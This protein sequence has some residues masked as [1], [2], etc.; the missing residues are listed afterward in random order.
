MKLVRR[1]FCSLELKDPVICNVSF[2]MWFYQ[3][4]LFIELLWVSLGAGT[5]LRSEDTCPTSLLQQLFIRL[6]PGWGKPLKLA[7]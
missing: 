4:H 5:A 2:S 6:S 3:R 7:H 1:W